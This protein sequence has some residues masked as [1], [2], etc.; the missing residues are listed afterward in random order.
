M[1]DDINDDSSIYENKYNIV[2]EDDYLGD[3]DESTLNEKKKLEK[4]KKNKEIKSLLKKRKRKIKAKDIGEKKYSKYKREE[5][6]D[7]VKEESIKKKEVIFRP[8]EFI[9]KNELLKNILKN[10]ILD[11]NQKEELNKLISEIKNKNIKD[12]VK[13]DKLDIVLDLENACIFAFMA[14]SET[15]KE[16]KEKFPQKDLKPVSFLFQNK[17]LI[18]GLIIRKGLLNFLE[19]ANTFCNF[20]INSLG[21]EEYL[22]QIKSIFKN[23]KFK[24]FQFLLRILLL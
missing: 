3:I 23:I 14:K 12:I 10:E 8:N 20:Y 4:L 17:R 21:V 24:R 7:K 16:L 5:V 15:I 19:F 18:M 2:R 1:S 9:S 22:I 6:N 11:M 13:K